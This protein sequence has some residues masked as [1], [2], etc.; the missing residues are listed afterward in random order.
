MQL[1]PA[2]NYAYAKEGCYR[3]GRGGP[4]VDMDVQIEG[5]G[6]L[7]ICDRCIGEAAE[8]AGFIV[9]RRKQKAE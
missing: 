4:V 1:L 6:A 3:C 2:A 7:G 9:R 8:T 5:E